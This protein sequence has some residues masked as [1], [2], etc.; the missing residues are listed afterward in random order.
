MSCI[1]GDKSKKYETIVKTIFG[2]FKS[3]IVSW[4]EVPGHG[5]FTVDLKSA[6]FVIDNRREHVIIRVPRPELTNFTIDYADVKLLLIEDNGLIKNS[7]KTGE[8]IIREQ[9]Q[10]AELS[11]RQNTSSNQA[12]IESACDNAERIL[13]TM[14]KQLNPESSDL[15]VEVLFFD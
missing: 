7:A 12:F 9:L 15:T 6:E 3:D 5:I 1:D 14:A 13:K 10:S 4:V 2:W 8:D 11:M